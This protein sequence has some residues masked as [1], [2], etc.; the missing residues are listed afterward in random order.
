MQMG[1]LTMNVGVVYY[2]CQKQSEFAPKPNMHDF[3][4]TSLAKQVLLVILY[5]HGRNSL[6]KLH[7]I[8]ECIGMQR[9]H[10]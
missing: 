6:Q 2:P 5:V 1:F 9:D 8:S 4:L 7:I 3:C 10:A